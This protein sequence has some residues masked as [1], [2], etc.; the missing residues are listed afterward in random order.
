MQCQIDIPNVAG[1]NDQE[2]TVGREFYL[3]CTGEWPKNLAQ[4]KLQLV[5]PEQ[6]KY[7]IQL[8]GFE[9][10]SP[11]TAEMKITAYKAVPVQLDNLKLTDGAQT[12]ELGPVRYS[13]KSVLEK[14]KDPQQQQ[15]PYGPFGPASIP[16][17]FEYILFVLALLGLIGLYVAQKIY[18]VIQR[19]RL[20]EKLKEHDSA[21]AP[22]PQFH[23]S[24]RKLQRDNPVF[25]GVQ[26]ET[27][28]VLAA[29]ESLYQMFGLFLIRQLHVPAFEW[30]EGLILK[31]VKKYH[32]TVYEYAG[33][34]LK[35]LLR[36]YNQAQKNR[37]TLT[38]K[39]ILVLAEQ[40]RKLAEKIDKNQG[41]RR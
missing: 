7:Q 20:L 3:A 35:K 15:E 10:R 14:P 38:D 21:L 19:R 17:P 23:Q 16:V 31:D 6:A 25:F 34:E 26:A 30:S 37:N 41:G 2:L 24:M 32:F 22:L 11:D 1:L 12:I 29:F 13:V 8:L 40:T 27:P 9:F 36:E 33:P 28:A 5:I 4:E 39:D 18:R